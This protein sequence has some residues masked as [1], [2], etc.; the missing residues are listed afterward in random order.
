MGCQSILATHFLSTSH[1]QAKQH[2]YAKV[3][4]FWK[5]M[6]GLVAE[7]NANIPSCVHRYLFLTLLLFS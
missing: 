1:A 6:A 3:R 5:Q 4:S 7:L 2:S